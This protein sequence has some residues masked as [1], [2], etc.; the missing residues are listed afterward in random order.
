MGQK[1]TSHSTISQQ[2]SIAKPTG[3]W[4]YLCGLTISHL[5]RQLDDGLAAVAVQK[6][7]Q[8]GRHLA[9]QGAA[10]AQFLG[11]LL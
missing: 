1:N 5:Q 4:P 2:M 11:D 7:L 8:E 9:A 6:V 3:F 10:L